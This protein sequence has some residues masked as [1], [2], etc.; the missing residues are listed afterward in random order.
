MLFQINN[1]NEGRK[2]LLNE[3]ELYKKLISDLTDEE[4]KLEGQIDWAKSIQ[5]LNFAMYDKTKGK[6]NSDSVLRYY[7]L[8]STFTNR[9]TIKDIYEETLN[10]ISNE[11]IRDLLRKYISLENDT[12]LAIEDY[13]N[14]KIEFVRPFIERNGLYNI[15]P[16]FNN[17]ERYGNVSKNNFLRLINGK[18]LEE[19]YGSDELTGIIVELRLHIAWVIEKYNKLEEFNQ[20]LILALDNEI[21]KE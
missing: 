11:N 19:H 6:F 18:K 13:N 12:N 17:N 7:Y 2:L 5:D 8:Q 4:L 15:D 21:K 3:H 16:I 10:K 9:P 20:S 14:Y 1:W